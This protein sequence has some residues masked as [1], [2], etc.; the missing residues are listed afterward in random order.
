MTHD[1]YEL[2]EVFRKILLF[3]NQKLF[4]DPPEIHESPYTLRKLLQGTNATLFCNAT[5][6][7]TP[8]VTWLVD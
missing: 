6:T 7:P 4:A 5:A 3:S 1:D 8:D 2:R